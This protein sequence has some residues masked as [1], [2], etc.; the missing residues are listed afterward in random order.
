MA[1]RTSATPTPI[2]ASAPGESV[3]PEDVTLMP[4]ALGE[5]E[6]P[7]C[8]T[9][10]SVS[11]AAEE[12]VFVAAE[13]D[14]ELEDEVVGDEDCVEVVDEDAAFCTMLHLTVVD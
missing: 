12:V 9:G 13:G 2:P 10:L 4:V 14:G 5:E 3:L 1:I 7:D 8:V 6:P 11:E